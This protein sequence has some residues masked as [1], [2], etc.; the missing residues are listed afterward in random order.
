MELIDLFP[1]TLSGTKLKSFDE[2]TML[3]SM[4]SNKFSF[5]RE[6]EINNG[7]YTENQQIL[8]EPE[9]A[10]IKKEIETI[11]LQ[12]AH[13]LGHVVQEIQ[14]VNS[15][16][17]LLR[18]GNEIKSHWHPNSYISG[19][20]YLTNGAP[21]EFIRPNV[22]EMLFGVEPNIVLNNQNLRTFKSFIINLE[23]GML[24]LF[25]SRLHHK[26]SVHKGSDR[27]SIA[28]NTM[29]VGEFGKPTMH[30]TVPRF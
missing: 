1:I 7:G 9:F 26:V 19:C 17:N 5:V 11:T 24:L 16:A 13:S 25:P 21:I 3:N 14:I 2:K 15:W 18:D 20:L 6:D 8:N 27:Y 12:Y 4:T 30:M 10:S 23:A 29:P 28:F 22:M